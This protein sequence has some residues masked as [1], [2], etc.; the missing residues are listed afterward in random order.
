M[1]WANKTPDSNPLVKVCNKTSAGFREKTIVK[2]ITTL[3]LVPGNKLAVLMN[4]FLMVSI[5]ETQIGF[6]THWQFGNPVQFNCEVRMSIPNLFAEWKQ[7]FWCVTKKMVKTIF[8]WGRIEL[9]HYKKINT[10]WNYCTRFVRLS[11]LKY[12]NGIQI[13]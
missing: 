1:I 3:M 2:T 9:S 6:F 5:K 12:N 4:W 13:L 10:G 8:G 7:M 11:R